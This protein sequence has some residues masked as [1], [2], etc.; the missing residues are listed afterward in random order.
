MHQWLEP[1]R[2]AHVPRDPDALTATDRVVRPRPVAVMGDVE[3]GE[4]VPVDI[5]PTGAG[6]PRV[7]PEVHALGYIDKL[8]R[9]PSASLIMEQR[10]LAV[11]RNHE[12]RPPIPVVV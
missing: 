7:I 10:Q 12:I 2:G 5:A 1:L 6:A 4:A 8:P 3:V 11:S 9:A